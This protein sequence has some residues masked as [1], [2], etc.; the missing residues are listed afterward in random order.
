MTH[1]AKVKRAFE[2]FNRTIVEL[3]FKEV[4]KYLTTN[5]F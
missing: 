1:R 3:K 5:I 4:S 2:P